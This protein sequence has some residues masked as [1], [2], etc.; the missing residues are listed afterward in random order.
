MVDNPELKLVLARK[1]YLDACAAKLL[2]ERLPELLAPKTP[3][4]TCRQFVTDLDVAARLVKEHDIT[5]FLV[6]VEDD[7]QQVLSRY[8]SEHLTV[9]VALHA[10][11]QGSLQISWQ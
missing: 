10:L 5:A 6:A 7:L 4:A 8:V 3:Q 11:R 9:A 2:V 1:L